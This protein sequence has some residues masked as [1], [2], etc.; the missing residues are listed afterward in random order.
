ML[1]STPSEVV[2]VPGSRVSRSRVSRRRSARAPA[3]LSSYSER[4]MARPS[5]P[6]INSFSEGTAA[7]IR[8][9][10]PRRFDGREVEEA[11]GV[12][13]QDLVLLLGRQAGKPL[14]HE[15]EAVRPR[16]VAVG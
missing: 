9:R 4:R 15:L 11:F 12:A 7:A 16:G 13:A 14:V 5:T 10:S 1:Y 8:P 6:T 3:A 2:A